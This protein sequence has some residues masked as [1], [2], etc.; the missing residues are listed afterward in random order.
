MRP[1]V[2]W[3]SLLA[4]GLCLLQHV[5]TSAAQDIQDEINLVQAELPA[6][7]DDQVRINAIRTLAGMQIRYRIATNF[8]G[9]EAAPEF[10]AVWANFDFVMYRE[11]YERLRAMLQATGPGDLVG[12]DFR[13]AL[14]DAYQ[15]NRDEYERFLQQLVQDYFG[16][17]APA[18]MKR[19]LLQAMIAYAMMNWILEPDLD[20]D[21]RSQTWTFPL[22]SRD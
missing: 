20:A 6:A 14:E 19:R 15:R 3:L 12:P 5:P 18:E 7:L 21:W 13:T 10:A 17:D 4:F 9:Y 8:R 2:H 16:I 22:C 11:G 1:V